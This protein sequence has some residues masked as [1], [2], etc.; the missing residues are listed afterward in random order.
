MKKALVFSI[1]ALVAIAAIYTVWLGLR[2]ESDV[3]NSTPKQAVS[4]ANNYVGAQ[5]CQQCHQ[6]QYQQWQSSDHAKAMQ[7]ASP[8]TVLGDFSNRVL[9]FH[10]IKTRLYQNN[11]QFLVDTSIDGA[12]TQT[13]SVSY[14]FGHYP[15]QQYLI[16]LDNG[17]V[18][19][20][21]IAW[22]SRPEGEGGQRWFHSVSY[23]HLTLPTICSV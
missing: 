10:S 20:L 1:V 19:A 14:T 4:Y 21:N 5:A 18:Q 2:V 22:D 11:G 23:T 6:E 9:E 13:F 8:A 17:H 15:L 7:E 12:T 16:E 3:A